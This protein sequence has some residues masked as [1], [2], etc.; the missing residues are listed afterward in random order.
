MTDTP[1]DDAEINSP[2][3]QTPVDNPPKHSWPTASISE[4][5]SMCV[6]PAMI[7][8]GIVPLPGQDTPEVDLPLARH[9]IDLLT[10]LEE[11]AT[12]NL[13]ESEQAEIDNALHDL[14]MTCLRLANATPQVSAPAEPPGEMSPDN[15]F[16]STTS[17]SS[18]PDET[19]P[20]DEDD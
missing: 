14:R 18:S 3:G 13:N 4:L 11:K 17:E 19:P 9:F 10:V 7:G 15:T 6:S 20:L 2:P 1:T 12:G 5:I 16:S 8:L